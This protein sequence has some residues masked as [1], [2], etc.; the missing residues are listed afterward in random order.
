[1][2]DDLIYFKRYKKDRD[3]KVRMVEARLKQVNGHFSPTQ[4]KVTVKDKVALVEMNPPTKL[5]FL[6]RPLI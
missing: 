2:D 5:I 6:T 4:V 3:S 1:M